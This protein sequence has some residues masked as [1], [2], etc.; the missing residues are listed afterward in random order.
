MLDR[1]SC[2]TKRIMFP[3][4]NKRSINNNIIKTL[5]F[6]ECC[7]YDYMPRTPLVLYILTH[8]I[9]KPHFEIGIIIIPTL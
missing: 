6:I 4:K 2:F 8:L 7:L 3:A 1:G 9:L 5:T